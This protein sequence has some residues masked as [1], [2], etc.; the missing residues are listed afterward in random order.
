MSQ[1]FSLSSSRLLIRPLQPED[2]AALCRYRSLPEIARFQSWESFGPDD[3]ARLIAGQAG[4]EPGVA[5]TWFQ[6]A[7]VEKATTEVVGDCGLH[8]PKGDARQMELG[9]TVSPSHQRRGYATEAVGCVLDFVFGSLGK[10]RAYAVTDVENGAAAALFRRL[11]FRQEAE[12]IEHRW[13]KGRWDSE[14][15]FAL[16]RREWEAARRA[17]KGRIA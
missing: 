8:C 9:I 15:V 13:Y 16:L 17:N 4:L 11:S 10:H 12:F 2:A 14:F 3:A 7:L 5:G 6:L 1:A